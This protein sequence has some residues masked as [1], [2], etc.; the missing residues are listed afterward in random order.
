[1]GLDYTA[2]LS[3]SSPKQNTYQPLLSSEPSFACTDQKP[4]S[5]LTG[6]SMAGGISQL[7]LGQSVSRGSSDG[8][9]LGTAKRRS[10]PHPTY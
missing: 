1:M 4:K 2:T 9:S 5:A 8:A 6:A 10:K 3:T 7:G